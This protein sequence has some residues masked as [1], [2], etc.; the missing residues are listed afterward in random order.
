MVAD[1]DGSPLSHGDS[2]TAWTHAHEALKA[3]AH[4]WPLLRLDGVQSDAAGALY[5][6]RTCPRCQSTLLK[7]I[8]REQAIEL[9]CRLARLQTQALEALSLAP[10]CPPLHPTALS[11]SPNPTTLPPR[12]PTP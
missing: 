4:L 8:V 10:A 5:E 11:P 2:S 7:P 6:M 9:C 3:D 12:P 1:K